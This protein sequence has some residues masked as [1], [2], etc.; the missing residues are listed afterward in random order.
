V[1]LR[2]REHSMLHPNFPEREK[3]HV[4][5]PVLASYCS[6][7]C[8]TGTCRPQGSR[9]VSSPM[10]IIYG[11]VSKVPQRGFLLSSALFKDGRG[12]GE[13]PC[14]NFIRFPYVLVYMYAGSRAVPSAWNADKITLEYQFGLSMP[15]APCFRL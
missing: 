5:E 14:H 10:P 13:T 6:L 15:L 12:S 1:F 3:E 9:F 7:L 8:S 4:L 2:E 11:F